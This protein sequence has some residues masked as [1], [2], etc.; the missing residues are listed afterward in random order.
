M[1]T[2]R[3]LPLDLN[4]HERTC[5]ASLM[6]LAGKEVVVWANVMF[7]CVSLNCQI[8]WNQRKRG[9]K[10]EGRKDTINSKNAVLSSVAVIMYCLLAEEDGEEDVR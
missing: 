3:E 4:G 1:M 10:R 2:L 5:T 7:V 8:Y 9:K 6:V